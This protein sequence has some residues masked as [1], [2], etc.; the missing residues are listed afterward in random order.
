MECDYKIRPV[1]FEDLPQIH[2]IYAKS[3]ETDTASW[4]YE[5]PSLDEFINRYSAIINNDFPYIIAEIEG[6]IIGYAYI[7]TYRARIGYRF[8]VE[9]SIYIN[10]EFYGKGI[11]TALLNEL[12]KIAK[13]KNYKNIIAVIGDTH[14]YASIKLHE[15]CGFKHIGTMPSIGYKFDKWL[16]SVLMQLEL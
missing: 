6:K 2:E 11:G 16:D 8:T 3:V 13:S 10:S 7:S 15:K 1:K 5:A 14:N 4:E 9:D 12:I